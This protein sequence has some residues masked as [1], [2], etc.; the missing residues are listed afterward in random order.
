[1]RDLATADLAERAKYAELVMK[2]SLCET[3]SSAVE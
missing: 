1:M 3:P 2:V